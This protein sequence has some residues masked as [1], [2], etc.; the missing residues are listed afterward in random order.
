M[1]K[2]YYIRTIRREQELVQVYTADAD[3][4]M[5]YFEKDATPVESIPRG[6]P[7]E[8]VIEE[9]R[10]ATPIEEAL[11]DARGRLDR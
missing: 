10:K 6:L 9:P 2:T 8:I 11:I 4:N 1:K 5:H 3:Q 7:T